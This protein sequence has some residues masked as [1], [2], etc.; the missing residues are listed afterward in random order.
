[1][2]MLK[3]IIDVIRPSS[4][5]EPIFIKEE[6]DAQRQIENL[7]TIFA[8]SVGETR[9]QIEADIR[10]L[11]QGIIG[12]NNI[13]FELK[14]SHLP[15]LILHD[16]NLIFEGLSAQVDYV[17]ILRNSIVIVEC[18]NLFGNLEVNSNGD[19]IRAIEFNG[20]YRKE[21][22]YSPITQNIRHFELI[23]QAR[24]ASATGFVGRILLDKGLSTMYRSIVVL[25]NPKTVINTKYAKKEIKDQIIRSDQLI[26]YLKKVLRENNGYEMK[27]EVMYSLADF[28]MK[29]HHDIPKDY[30]NKYKL[31]LKPKLEPEPIKVIP[32]EETEIYKALKEYRLQISR[33]KDIKAYYIFN[34]SQ[35][36]E[37][38][39]S[40]PVSSDGL[41]KVA[42]FN[43]EK[44]T[45]YGLE[46]IEIVNKYR[47]V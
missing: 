8:L 39:K 30:I 23:K 7:K 41:L 15:M 38:I 19:F 42:G 31:D 44:V 10:N 24:L 18:K 11:N 29:L 40:M 28:F 5:S 36:E 33:E 16:L 46:I 34:N 35:M 13:A 9:N 32:I 12:E 3:K 4:I 26:T 37:I 14:N 21:G 6:S 17:V 43:K 45:V 2:T 47:S 25:A 27:D 1:M 20:R 22:I